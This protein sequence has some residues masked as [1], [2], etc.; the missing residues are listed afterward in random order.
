MLG[1]IDCGCYVVTVV[2]LERECSASQVH[3][4]FGIF[5]VSVL[6]VARMAFL[7]T[8]VCVV[9]HPLPVLRT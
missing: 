6:E 1:S 9:A 7:G 5:S 3:I 4:Y 8:D 2:R